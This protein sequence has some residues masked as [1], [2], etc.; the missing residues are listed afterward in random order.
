MRAISATAVRVTGV[1]AF[2][3]EHGGETWAAGVAGSEHLQRF[4]GHEVV[5]VGD[6]SEGEPEL[7]SEVEAGTFRQGDELVSVGHVALL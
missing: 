4:E 5:V 6:E 3:G 7:G 2:G 1:S